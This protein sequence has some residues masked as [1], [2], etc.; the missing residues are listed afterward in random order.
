MKPRNTLVTIAPIKQTEK[1]VGS[2]ILP[3]RQS[4]QYQEA[5]VLDV[6]PG[7]ITQKGEV[8]P[9]RDLKPGQI[10]LVHV[11]AQRQVG[12]QQAVLEPIGMDFKLDDGRDSVLVEQSQ[13]VAI[14]A[15]PEDR[16]AHQPEDTDEHVAG[17]IGGDSPEYGTLP[18]DAT[19]ESDG[20]VVDPSKE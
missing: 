4:Q 10:V 1:K 15:E 18:H 13:I 12:P 2:I 7:M 16:A 19:Y 17:R 20:P 3:G 5:E 11:K 8:S 6:G 9:C 14:L